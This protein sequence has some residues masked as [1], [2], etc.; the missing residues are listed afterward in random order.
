[1]PRII[2]TT[3]GSLGDLH[4]FIAIGR[5][6]AARGAQ[7]LLAIPEDGVAKVRAA[8]LKA[9]PI[10]PSAARICARL[11]IGAEAF[12]A[13]II[14]DPNFV[15]D[16]VLMPALSESTAAL[17]RLVGRGDVLAGSLFAFAAEIVAEK[18]GVPLATMILQPMTL[19]SVWRPPAAPRFEWMRHHPQGA[20]G[21]A[22][23]H[24]VYAL[25]R[26][27]LRRRYGKMV[28]AVRARH[29]LGPRPG[30]LLLDRGRRRTRSC[31]A[32]RRCLARC[33]PTPRT[34]RRWWDCPSSVTV[35]RRRGLPPKWRRSCAK[36]TH[37]WSSR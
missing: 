19:F 37:R 20:V 28:D 35:A 12:A 16:E 22:W 26:R 2:L 17:D 27:M 34:T 9:V 18:R 31:A 15:L 32:G 10:L 8:G 7:V 29:G 11:G 6:L 23:N 3:I 33:R 36:V 24:I 30:A 4:P 5:A 25:G 13:R 14:A 21:R 1:M